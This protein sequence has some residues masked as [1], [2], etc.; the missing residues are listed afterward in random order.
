MKGLQKLKYYSEGH[1]YFIEALLERIT[2]YYGNRLI[3]LVIFG[4]Y[5]R[6]ENRLNSDLDL[7]LILDSKQKIGRLKLQGEF[8]DQVEIP[9]EK[10]TP[11][12]WKEGIY[13]EIS[14]IILFQDQAQ[15]FLPI[16]LD[17]VDHHM[18]VF[19]RNNFFEK[20]L[21]DVKTKMNRWGSRKKEIGGHWYWEIRPGLGWEETIHYDQ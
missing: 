10:K 21:G 5:A 1:Q 14:S 8:V 9:L 20:V 16:Y 11:S 15:H 12:L 6:G 3:S 4:S 13:S 7:L 17:M 18:I 19:D 2:S